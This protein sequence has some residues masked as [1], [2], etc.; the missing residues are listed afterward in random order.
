M[1]GEMRS[2]SLTAPALAFGDD[3]TGRFKDGVE[4]VAAQPASAA[5]ETDNRPVAVNVTARIRLICRFMICLSGWGFVRQAFA[6]NQAIAQVT[7][8]RLP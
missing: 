6:N 1:S 3:D 8:M 4:V 2:W 5:I 7:A